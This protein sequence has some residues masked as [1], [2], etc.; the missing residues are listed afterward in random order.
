M[1]ATPCGQRLGNLEAVK[2]LFITLVYGGDAPR[3]AGQFVLDFAAEQ[4]MIRQYDADQH[5]ELLKELDE[6]K[7]NPQVQMDRVGEADLD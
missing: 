6:T 2:I 1:L 4:A 3:D 5:L 7:S